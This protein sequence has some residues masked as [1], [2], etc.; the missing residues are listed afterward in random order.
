[1]FAT[2]FKC[3]PQS[4]IKKQKRRCFLQFYFLPFGILLHLYARWSMV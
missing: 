3:L 1:M 2:K 4:Y